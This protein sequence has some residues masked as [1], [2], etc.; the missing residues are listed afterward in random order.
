VEVALDVVAKRGVQGATVARIAAGAGVTPAAL[1]GYFANR[2]EILV[3]A[4]D[5]LFDRIRA[6]N[7][8][9]THTN[10][11]ERLR[12][13]GLHHTKLVASKEDGFVFPLFEFIAAPPE[14]GLREELRARQM[15]RIEELVEIVRDGQRQGTI[16]LEADPYQVAW[17]IVVKAW[18]EDVAELMGVTGEWDKERSIRFLNLI[19]ESVAVGD[20]STG[21]GETTRAMTSTSATST[22]VPYMPGPTVSE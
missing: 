4:L 13:I 6:V 12:E 14:E 15:E 1:Y 11:L 7:R 16:A 17:L 21:V 3:S 18:A 5:V 22:T 20:R 9:S 8:S 2:K 10:A 19:L